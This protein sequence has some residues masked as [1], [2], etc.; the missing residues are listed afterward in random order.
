MKK[1]LKKFNRTLSIMLAVAMVLTMV[2]QTTMPVLAA[3]VEASEDEAEPT[4]TVEEGTNEDESA[5]AGETITDPE[6]EPDEE[7]TT[8]PEEPAEPENPE[9]TE[10]PETSENPEE[11]EEPENPENPEVEAPEETEEPE[12]EVVE[13][14]IDT[15]LPADSEEPSDT[16][17]EQITQTDPNAIVDKAE[18]KIIVKGVSVNDEGA[19]ELA[20]L[21]SAAVHF[22]DGCASEDGSEVRENVDITFRVLAEAGYKVDSVKYAAA[23]KEEDLTLAAATNSASENGGIYTVAKS[24]FTTGEKNTKSVLIVV[25]TVET[26]FNVKAGSVEGG[27]TVNTVKTAEDGTT[28]L[29]AIGSGKKVNYSEANAITLAMS[30]MTAGKTYVV[31]ASAGGE[32]K[33]LTAGSEAEV[34]D[35]TKYI[36]YTLN[37]SELEGAAQY[38]DQDITVTVEEV[39][40]VTVV[41]SAITK[42][43]GYDGTIAAA[44][45]PAEGADGYVAYKES[46]TYNAGEKV[47]FTITPKADSNWAAVTADNITAQLTKD[48]EKRD[49]TLS[50]SVPGLTP[51]EGT[52]VYVAEIPADVEAGYTL[53]IDV[54]AELG[55]KAKVITFTKTGH[56][57]AEKVV[58][59]KGGDS[60]ADNVIKTGSLKTM[61]DSYTVNI[62]SREGYRLQTVNVKVTG[63]YDADKSAYT[64]TYVLDEAENYGEEGH[65]DVESNYP[66]Y[67]VEKAVSL[68]GTKES[69]AWTASAVE[70]EVV[71]SETIEGADEEKQVTFAS[72]SKASG[73]PYGFEVAVFENKGENDVVTEKVSYDKDTQ[74]ATIAEGTQ[75]L[76]FSVAAETEPE[77]SLKLAGES[78]VADDTG[79]LE[80]VSAAAGKFDYRV[81]AKALIGDK[82]HISIERQ[83]KKLTANFENNASVSYK[84][85][86][87]EDKV[88]NGNLTSGSA[89]NVDVDA[90]LE[91]EVTPVKGQA[92]IASVTYKVGEEGAEQTASADGEGKYAFSVK[93][94]DDITVEV[95]RVGD[96][97]LFVANGDDAQETAPDS[98]VEVDYEKEISAYLLDADGN[99][100]SIIN[101]TV[102]ED[103]AFAQTKAVIT[104]NVATLKVAKNEY[105]KELTV[106]LLK[107]DRTT[108]S[109]KVVSDKAVEEVISYTNAQGEAVTA[110]SL[111]ADT[112]LALHVNAKDGNVSKLRAAVIATPAGGAAVPEK[113]PEA[114]AS[115]NDNIDVSLNNGTLVITASALKDKVD[116]AGTILLY[117]IGDGEKTVL[118]SL[119]VSVGAPIMKGQTADAAKGLADGRTVSVNINV[120]DEVKSEKLNA[121][122]LGYEIKVTKPEPASLTKP[123]NFTADEWVKT[124]ASMNTYLGE[125][126][127]GKFVPASAV[128][129]GY[130]IQVLGNDV[131]PAKIDGIKILVTPVQYTDRSDRIDANKVSGTAAAEIETGTTAPIYSDTLKLGKGANS[132]TTGQDE[133]IVV[134][135]PDFAADAQYR[136][137]K[138]EI[139]DSTT[140]MEHAGAEDFYARW[141]AVNGA[142]TVNA[143]DASYYSNAA[144]AYKNLAVKVT[145]F[146]EDGDYGV[147][148][149]KKLSVINGIEDIS[150][151]IQPEILSTGKKVTVKS[152]ITYNYETYN[153]KYAPKK[154]AVTYRIVGAGSAYDDEYGLDETPV[155]AKLSTAVDAK[156]TKAVDVNPKNGTI[157]VAAGFDASKNKPAENKFRVLA[158][159]VDYEGNSTKALSQVITIISADTVLNELTVFEKGKAN[160]WSDAKKVTGD[161]QVRTTSGQYRLAMLKPGTPEKAAYNLSKDVVDYNLLDV[162]SSNKGVEVNAYGYITVKKLGKTN[163]TM[164]A[165][166]NAKNKKDLKNVN[167]VME[168]TEL[169]AQVTRYQ[170]STFK[171]AVDTKY[172]NAAG[173]IDVTGNTTGYFSVNIVK[174]VVDAGGEESYVRFALPNYAL[175]FKNA[176]KVTPVETDPE[177]PEYTDDAYVV[178]TGS[179]GKKATVITVN[180]KGVKPAKKF[181]IT[182]LN[183]T[184]DTLTGNA[185][186]LAL[187]DK[188]QR[189]LADGSYHTVPVTVTAAKKGEV[190]P[191]DTYVMLS[192]DQTKK[193]K[194]NVNDVFD[195]SLDTPILLKKTGDST[196]VFSVSMATDQAEG[197]NLI[198]TLGTMNDGVFTQTHKEARLTLKAVKANINIKATAKYTLNPYGISSEKLVVSGGDYSVKYDGYKD[199]DNTK[200]EYIDG[201]NYAKN[202]I[203]KDGTPNKFNEYFVATGR[204]GYVDQIMINPA[205]S[206]DQLKNLEDKDFLKANGTGYITVSNGAKAVDV[207]LTIAIKVQKDMKLKATATP[208]IEGKEVITDIQIM[209]G[210]NPVALA[211]YTA[212][213]ESFKK[214]YTKE[215]ESNAAEKAAEAERLSKGIIRVKAAEVTKGSDTVVLKVLPANTAASYLTLDA[216]TNPTPLATYG[217]EVPSVKVTI[218][219]NTTTNKVVVS[220]GDKKWTVARSDWNA[221]EEFSGW[222]TWRPYSYKNRLSVAVDQKITVTSDTDYVAFESDNYNAS[223]S[224]N[225]TIKLDKAKMLEAMTAA[226][227]KVNWGKKVNVK[228]TFSYLGTAEEG[229]DAAELLK[230]DSVTFA[231]TLPEQ[232][233]FESAD[234][235]NA[236]VEANKAMLQNLADNRTA[237]YHRYTYYNDTYTTTNVAND[238]A[239]ELKAAVLD[240]AKG[241]T[242]VITTKGVFGA[243]LYT[244][245][246]TVSG[247]SYEFKVLATKPYASGVAGWINTEYGNCN[248]EAAK[249]LGLSFYPETTTDA[250]A[251]KLRSELAKANMLTRNIS[252]TV[253]EVE[254]EAPTTGNTGSLTASVT[255]KDSSYEPHDE[256]NYTADATVRYT[257]SQLTAADTFK[258][259]QTNGLDQKLKENVANGS[260]SNLTQLFSDAYI[261]SKGGIGEDHAIGEEMKKALI[262]QIEKFAAT[263]VAE[264]PY[265][266]VKGIDAESFECNWDN[267]SSAWKLAFEI[268]YTDSTPKAEEA[269]FTVAILDSDSITVTA[270]EVPSYSQ[271]EADLKT[272]AEAAFKAAYYLIKNVA[273]EDAAKAEIENM[274]KAAILN[275]TYDAAE[276]L[277]IEVKNFTA[278]TAEVNGMIEV[279]VTYDADAESPS[280]TGNYTFVIVKN[281]DL[282]GNETDEEGN[283]TPNLGNR[284]KVKDLIKASLTPAAINKAVQDYWKDHA[285]ANVAAIDLVDSIKTLVSTCLTNSGA[286]NISLVDTDPVAIAADGFKL[287]ANSTETGKLGAITIKLKD[288]TEGAENWEDADATVTIPATELTESILFQ[289]EAEFRK[290]VKDSLKTNGIAYNK[291][292]FGEDGSIKE[293]Q[294]TAIIT[295]I[296]T[297]MKQEKYATNPMW[298]ASSYTTNV[299]AEAVEGDGA[300]EYTA[301]LIKNVKTTIGTGEGATETINVKLCTEDEMS[302]I[303]SVKITKIGTV[304]VADNNGESAPAEIA[305]SETDLALELAATVTGTSG[306]TDA[307]KAL[308]WK[309]T[310]KSDATLTG[311]V[312]DIKVEDGKLLIPA[313]AYAAD[314]NVLVKL[315]ATTAGSAVS[316]DSDSN[317]AEAYVKVVLTEKVTAIKLMDSTGKAEAATSY[318][319]GADAET[320]VTFKS[321]LEGSHI[322]AGT[323]K[324]TITAPTDKIDNVTFDDN[325]SDGSTLIMKLAKALEGEKE[326]TLKLEA[327]SDDNKKTENVKIKVI[328]NAKAA[329]QI[330]L[331]FNAEG[332]DDA[333]WTAGTPAA[334]ETA[335]T[336]GV[337]TVKNA[338]AKDVKIP[339]TITD[340]SNAQRTWKTPTIA[341]KTG[342]Q[343]FMEIS[344]S[345]AEIAVEA[346]TGKEKSKTFL[347]VKNIMPEI[348]KAQ[349]AGAD[350]ESAEVKPLVLTLTVESDAEGGKGQAALKATLDFDLV[351]EKTITGIKVEHDSENGS[352]EGVTST[353]TGLQVTKKDGETTAI[354]KATV[355]GAHVKAEGDDQGV[356][357]KITSK[358]ARSK[359]TISA[360]GKVTIPAESVD[361]IIK[362]T[363]TS[364][365]DK[366]VIKTISLKVVAAEASE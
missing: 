170:D 65:E 109:F 27:V 25:K 178:A 140:G 77:V 216:K 158:E 157:T 62:A 146:T 94:T 317:K 320:S 161:L 133:D 193:T 294:K 251:A 218:A 89:A 343:E 314:G 231:I 337:L 336:N 59:I 223:G 207:K 195:G 308:T 239:Y 6:N 263:V 1:V 43:A 15:T 191:A 175:S 229:K 172:F 348:L 56:A 344:S 279:K 149:V 227:K 85:V 365:V 35:K 254:I 75:Y 321:A 150:L 173:T 352:S 202:L 177:Y 2:P 132:L 21:S 167:F 300:T 160:N 114:E 162:K 255:V 201:F 270:S 350:G 40:A 182:I 244:Y 341:I 147:S 353:A 342:A 141:D 159:A 217:I 81:A 285:A 9:P 183:A 198:A 292:W 246:L 278:P 306:A 84:N 168:N 213:G 126:A 134:A 49:I 315:T 283:E 14:T 142:V 296:T 155:S 61:A 209:N 165:K 154:K 104:D 269:E 67:E 266:G 181:E 245:T 262:A 333:A 351:V 73:N 305:S 83:A 112:T 236:A 187:A 66:R 208:V 117:E 276:S 34:T 179:T 92:P 282:L 248:A 144:D 242:A 219:A 3:E 52:A 91:I 295:A 318:E 313:D 354:L 69:K 72:T 329:S 197:Y 176:K 20:D 151:S 232:E 115:A 110:A 96:E 264:N 119:N 332:M 29:E 37:V 153:K 205:L 45:I 39:A 107:A 322:V 258:K 78:G 307:D 24:A 4:T 138:V 346:G 361:N 326:V 249:T 58:T 200:Y 290:A 124:Q 319:A 166:S 304:T 226:P 277:K 184:A 289:S 46:G 355:E 47:A 280:Q 30:G 268:T 196:A 113:V 129:G 260:I 137:V 90:P 256:Y 128:N 121:G 98:V 86:E 261:A 38:E 127:T 228:A 311:G 257:F 122:V 111:N 118:G 274:I 18:T 152:A 221:T 275:P 316:G 210:K 284:E 357:W 224:Q 194:A 131:K 68:K 366:S 302:L 312:K 7:E 95:K 79:L 331:G 189:I 125:Y 99:K 291:N 235:L 250:L 220:T 301:T 16:F 171:K 44:T 324:A 19:E 359:A 100:I 130:T 253:E 241:T 364:K 36:P 265:L 212:E 41:A 185:P 303:K 299:K 145:A 240:M 188:K 26:Q 101:A 54:K 102:K 143:A 123:E 87:N 186:K 53:T 204:Y 206:A 325:S 103:K 247:K 328:G 356:T 135:V 323:T 12:E 238:V 148:G 70:I 80:L 13:P 297:E 298:K 327:G 358:G 190:I 93:A 199:Y 22:T 88:I 330:S 32:A 243:N 60:S 293:D 338:T 48:G 252:L 259:G 215:L 272:A 55:E 339:V 214:Y 31:T 334:G 222:S 340:S 347:V 106:T 180:N 345:N 108:V 310:D 17:M 33:P 271:N 11:S 105:E 120:P 71:V 74:T 360:D 63:T 335:A 362:V 225:L 233:G 76:T 286:S 57:D 281:D 363:A 23:E 28:S 64:E 169:Y 230:S 309:V 163:F 203:Q 116:A 82:G 8:E 156:G 288:T 267:S 50:T 51:A 136:S 97:R 42:T 211:D 164:A 234:A 237:E 174:K 349:E 139:I 287:P 273:T 192:A 5:D 10:E